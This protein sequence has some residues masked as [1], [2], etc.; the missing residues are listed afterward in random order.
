MNDKFRQRANQSYSISDL[1]KGNDLDIVAA[2]L[3]LLGKLKVSSVQLYRGQPVVEVTLVG[4]FK[5]T[6]N[7]KGNAMADFLE[8]NGD[9]TLDDV[10]DGIR[11]QINKK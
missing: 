6:D 9:M 2:S 5:S 7:Q 3:L 4:E 1:L 8:Q 11:R 10:F